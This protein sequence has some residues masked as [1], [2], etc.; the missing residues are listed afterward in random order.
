[1]TGFVSKK[2]MA[3]DKMANKTVVRHWTNPIVNGG[4]SCW[5]YPENDKEFVSWMT[6]NCPSSEVIYRYN[7]G[8]PMYT[9][10]I[11]EPD[12]ATMFALQWL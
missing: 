10:S 9:V 12:E 4:W 3:S 8:D 7:S 11:T 2:L 1:M 6:E 5:V